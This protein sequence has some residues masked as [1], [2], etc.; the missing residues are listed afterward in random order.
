M[1][2]LPLINASFLKRKSRNRRQLPIFDEGEDIISQSDRK[3]TISWAF[4]LETI[5]YYTNR[6][7]S[8]SLQETQLEIQSKKDLTN[9]TKSILKSKC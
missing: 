3:M 6:G 8:F 2:L 7:I 1:C 5:S 4:P 9:C